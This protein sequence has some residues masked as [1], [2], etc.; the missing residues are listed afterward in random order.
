MLIK[1]RFSINGTTVNPIYNGDLARISEKESGQMFFRENLSSSLT[2]VREDYDFLEG[3]AFSTKFVLLIEAFTLPDGYYW[4]PFWTG[5]FYKTDCKWDADNRKVTVTPMVQDAYNT[6]LA[7]LDKEYDLA[8]MSIAKVNLTVTKRPLLQLYVPG[9][10][11]VSCFLSG[12]MWEQDVVAAET[13]TGVLTGTYFFSQASSFSRITVTGSG[14]PAA[15]VGDYIREGTGTTWRGKNGTYEILRV[16]DTGFYYYILRTSGGYDYFESDVGY[17]TTTVPSTIN[18]VPIAGNGGTG[19]LT[20]SNLNISVYARLL[21]NAST[22]LG[23]PTSALPTEDL[24]DYNRNYRR[25]I[26]Y[27]IDCV[28]MTPDTDTDPTEYGLAE[29]GTYFQ[30]PYGFPSYPKYYPIARST[31]GLS[32]IWFDYDNYSQTAEE[33]GRTE[34]VMKD[35]SPLSAI[36]SALLAEIDPSLSHAGTTTYSSI[37]YNST[38]PL[39]STAFTILMTPKS[40]I[41]AGEYQVPAQ[42]APTTLGKIF[43]ML[44]NVFQC[45]WYIDSSDRLRIEHI[46]WFKNGGAYTGTPS[47]A[48]DLTAK[49]DPKNGKALAFGVN[50][51][52][53]DKQ[54]M[55]ERLEFEWMDRV[56]AGFEGLPIEVNSAFVLPG[57]VDKINAGEVTTDVDYML[58]NPGAVNPDGFA[59]LGAVADGD[60]YILPFVEK[61]IEDADLELQNGYL[62]WIHLHPYYWKADLPASSVEIN[63]ASD[64]A[65]GIKRTKKQTVYYPSIYDLDPMDLIKTDLGDGEI[66]KLSLNLSSRMHTIDLRYDTE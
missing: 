61:T 16:L 40:N 38:N 9:D 37:L 7:G 55:A 56:S 27:A 35:A 63:G 17:P 36:L 30:E 53:Y 25:A 2:F 33:N 21:T 65:D 32:S 18:F 20:G 29:D 5:Y 45:Y 23:N 10:S 50:K 46:S 60:D 49:F 8:K 14:T 52:S 13:D 54:E 34:Y 51:Y 22:V 6:I 62:S 19:T 1:Y 3:E 39:G 58:L 64:T 11:V 57:K 43:A 48:A 47:Y 31:W 66:E 12:S 41:T 44:A 28:S 15:L 42:K 26:G 4:D 59:L 24:V